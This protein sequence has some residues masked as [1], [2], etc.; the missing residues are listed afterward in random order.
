M[1]PLRIWIGYDG[2]QDLG[3]RVCE[4]SIRKNAS[5]PVD[6]QPLVLGEL[7]AAGLYSRPTERRANGQLWD[8]ISD[9]PMATEFAL[10]RFLVPALARFEGW[11]LFVDC[12]FMFRADIAKLF[13]YARDEYAVMCVKHDYEQAEG[14]KMDARVQTSY[15]RKNW[16]SLMLFNCAHEATKRL[17][18]E[19]VNQWRGLA[20]HQMAWAG[21]AEIGSIPSNWNK[22]EIEAAAVHF[23]HGMPNVPGY[24]SVPYADEWREYAS[25]LEPPIA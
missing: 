9:A 24:E 17:S 25:K 10:T 15:W 6:I 3:Y 21:S 23:T 12:D 8:V 16:S 1:E 2:R 19:S 7:A 13:S 14:L 20:L 18:V 22:I 11:A 5:V 4:A